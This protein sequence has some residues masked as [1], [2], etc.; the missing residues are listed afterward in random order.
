VLNQEELT[1]RYQLAT[2]QQYKDLKQEWFKMITKFSSSTSEPI[3]LQGML[4]LIN[5][6]DEWEN[7]YLKVVKRKHN[8][9]KEE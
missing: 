8:N 1:K 9:E 2:S 5:R 6:T 4:W 7:D 3:L